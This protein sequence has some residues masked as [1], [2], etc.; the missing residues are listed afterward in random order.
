MDRQKKI[1][2]KILSFV[3]NIYDLFRAYAQQLARGPT[4]R[5][6]GR[7]VVVA[8]AVAVLV[9]VVTAALVVVKLWLL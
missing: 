7:G 4:K 3:S 2:Y 8:A 5:N 6:G 1:K 9:V